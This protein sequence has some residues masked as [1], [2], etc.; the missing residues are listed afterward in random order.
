MYL[1]SLTVVN[2]SYFMYLNVSLRI[3][4]ASGAP[5]D[6]GLVWWRGFLGDLDPCTLR[7]LVG[8]RPEATV[9][10][11]TKGWFITTDC[12]GN[13]WWKIAIAT[14]WLIASGCL[15]RWSH[16][17]AYRGILSVFLLPVTHWWS[18]MHNY[19]WYVRSK[20]ASIEEPEQVRSALARRPIDHPRWS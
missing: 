2:L 20:W 7:I 19:D 5:G 15:G 14:I 18:L 8:T 10:S 13:G 17:R 9:I 3:S 11:T 4:A 12:L 16:S 6:W 1:Y